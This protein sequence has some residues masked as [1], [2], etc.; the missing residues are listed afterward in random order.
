MPRLLAPVA[1]E[2]PKSEMSARWCMER[3]LF[4]VEHQTR[5]NK[6]FLCAR[7]IYPCAH[8]CAPV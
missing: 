4:Q 3:G 8:T 1:Q 6:F 2:N 7:A 5:W